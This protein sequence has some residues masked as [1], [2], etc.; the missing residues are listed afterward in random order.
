[1]DDDFQFCLNLGLLKTDDSE[2]FRPANPIYSDVIVRTLALRFKTILSDSLIGAFLDGKKADMSSM[3]K[4]F[5]DYWRLN[6]DIIKVIT[7]YPE[8]IPHLYL[9]LFLRKIGNGSMQ[10]TRESALGMGRVDIMV[11]YAGLRYP[12]EVKIF[13]PGPAKNKEAIEQISRYLDVSGA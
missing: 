10:V 13:E 2:K 4:V 1:M 3:L 12:L 8:A 11:V 9:D 7:D 5:Q 6:A